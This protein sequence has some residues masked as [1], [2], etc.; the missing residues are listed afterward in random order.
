MLREPNPIISNS[1]VTVDE[2]QLKQI[3]SK[4]RLILLAIS[5]LEINHNQIKIPQ[6]QQELQP[7][8]LQVTS[9][10]QQNQELIPADS[11]A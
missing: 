10:L 9:L 3:Q 1:Q 11:F 2:Q 4:I 6:E 7:T 8:L 5:A